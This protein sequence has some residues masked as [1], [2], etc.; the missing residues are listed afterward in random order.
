MSIEHLIYIIMQYTLKVN[1]KKNIFQAL[2]DS[3]I[4]H[5]LQRQGSAE[6]DDFI[7]STASFKQVKLLEAYVLLKSSLEYL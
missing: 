2:R 1:S 5:P 7:I 3:G 6:E 4:N